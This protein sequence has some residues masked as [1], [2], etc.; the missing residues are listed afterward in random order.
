MIVVSVIFVLM[1]GR[2]QLLFLLVEITWSRAA[3]IEWWKFGIWRIWGRQ[4]QQFAPT[5]QLTGSLI[6]VNY[7][8]SF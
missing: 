1:L 3:M 2:W 5:L 4:W 6:A 7:S 8:R